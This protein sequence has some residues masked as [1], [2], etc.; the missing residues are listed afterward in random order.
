MKERDFQKYL[1][2]ATAVEWLPC[3]PPERDYLGAV[4]IPVLGEMATLPEL[5]PQ[6]ADNRFLVVLVINEQA[7]SPVEYRRENRE[8][9]GWLAT[10]RPE[11]IFWLDYTENHIAPPGVGTARKIG[12]DA[13][14]G[15]VA[16]FSNAH[17]KLL[18]SLDGDTLVDG[19][20]FEAALSAFAGHPSWSG[21]IFDFVHRPVPEDTSGAIRIYEN[22]LRH[23]RDGLARAGSPYAYI[24]IGSAMVARCDAY[25]KCGG[26]RSR[27]GGEDFY[28]LQALRKTGGIGEINGAKVYP[29]GRISAR[30][31][32]G[33]GPGLRKIIEA[34]GR[35]DFEPDWV[36]DELRLA[37]NC[38]RES[39]DF[40]ALTNL[41]EIM[42]K[43]LPEKSWEF[44]AANNFEAS[45]Q[46]ISANVKMGDEDALRRGFMT[47]FDA[48]RT[49]KFIHFLLQ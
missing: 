24:P 47:W 21:A 22:Y 13:A 35:M 3:A 43:R 48:F 41:P 26:M 19:G 17:E 27:A 7:D 32:F 36:F 37:L 25:I 8:L 10:R 29:S 39:K 5:L 15:V 14:L 31:P 9:L 11:N 6:L 18:F 33:T 42:R 20:Y 12:L 44:F 38:V 45:W 16:D 34:G 30:V 1:S 49:L 2:K 46:K 4:V 40:A 23:Y 28:F